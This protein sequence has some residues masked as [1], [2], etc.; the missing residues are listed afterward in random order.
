MNVEKAIE[1]YNKL[2]N[3]NIVKAFLEAQNMI[4]KEIRKE[5]ERKHY[6]SSNKYD[7]YIELPYKTIELYPNAHY[8]QH[9][10]NAIYVKSGKSPNN[11][12]GN[13]CLSLCNYSKEKIIELIEKRIKN[14]NEVEKWENTNIEVNH[15]KMLILMK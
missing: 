12:S 7:Y 13:F 14:D 3:N 11:Y 9:T 2:H 5:Q 6:K 1:T 15:L 8:R 4:V 10:Y